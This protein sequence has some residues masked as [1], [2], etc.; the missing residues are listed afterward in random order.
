MK[1]NKLPFFESTV[2]IINGAW[3]LMSIAIL[4]FGAALSFNQI[5]NIDFE[6]IQ[7]LQENTAVTK[8][9]I[10]HVA[11]TNTY[12]NE[13]PI[14]AYNYKFASPIGDLEWTSYD[15]GNTQKVGD[16]VFVEYS[17][18][19]PDINRIVGMSNSLGEESMFMFTIPLFVGLIALIV[20]LIKGKAKRRIINSGILAYAKLISWKETNTTINDQVVYQY[21]FMFKTSNGKEVNISCKTHNTEVLEQKRELV[22]YPPNE[23]EKGIMVD[24]LPLNVPLYIK[25]NWKKPEPPDWF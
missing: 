21:N 18:L 9:I 23:P 13:E 10:T 17:E 6:A 11:E 15:I 16:S 25:S 5:A 19:R 1:Q 7:Y 2:V 20:N 24:L 22:I 3:G 4:L 12:I 14:C 8:G